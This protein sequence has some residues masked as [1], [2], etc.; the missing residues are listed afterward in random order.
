MAANACVSPACAVCAPLLAPP[1]GG[2]AD[3]ILVPSP[4]GGVHRQALPAG[5]RLEPAPPPARPAGP[6]RQ[7]PG[8]RAGAAR[9]HRTVRSELR[10]LH[11]AGRIGDADYAA[12]RSAF[13]DARRTARRL[14]GTRRREL[15]AVIA[16]VQGIAARGKLTPSRLAPLW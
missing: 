1:A 13:D 4:D 8:R 5:A 3:T 6:V 15:R 10:R 16:I 2:R 7:A 12:R 14:T 9:S 11:A